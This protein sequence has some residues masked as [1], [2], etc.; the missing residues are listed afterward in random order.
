MTRTITLTE[1]NQNP[2]RA[3]RLADTEADGVVVLRR[4][5]AAYRLVAVEAPADPIDALVQAGL[6]SPPRRKKR[7]A[8]FRHIDTDANVTAMLDEDRNRLGY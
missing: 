3:T 6:A 7:P 2:S 5:T 8:K 1:F 4:G